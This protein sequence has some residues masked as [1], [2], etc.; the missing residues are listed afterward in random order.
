MPA[1]VRYE[2]DLARLQQRDLRWDAGAKTLT[3]TMPPLE[4]A[5]PEFDLQGTREYG[6]GAVLMALTD[7]ERL[8]DDANRAKAKADVIAQARAEPVMRLAREAHA[9]AIR[10]SFA[11][12]LRAA[13]I[14]A[15]VEVE[16][17]Q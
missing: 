8:L 7:V 4:I 5:A 14:E 9:R 6:S 12:P 2:I 11:M 17:T 3:I 1:N 13:G 16:M 10:N 15:Q